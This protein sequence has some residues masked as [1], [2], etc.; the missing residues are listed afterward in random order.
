MSTVKMCIAGVALLLC[1]APVLAFQEQPAGSAAPAPAAQQPSAT[2]P[3][4][5]NTNLTAPDAG[6]NAGGTEVRIPGLG[7]LGNLPKM[8]FGLELLYGAADS[9]QPEPPQ[10]DDGRDEL[11]IRGSV[12]HKF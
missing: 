10:R 9:K 11:T 7:K 8:D 3:A 1:S 2:E 4:K 5:P 6:S 12:K